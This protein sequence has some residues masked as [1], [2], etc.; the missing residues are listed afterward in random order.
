MFNL[1]RW[2]KCP[3]HFF[4][5]TAIRKE[6]DLCPHL[7]TSAHEDMYQG[8]DDEKLFANVALFIYYCPLNHKYLQWT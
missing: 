7:V 8:G 1:P 4:V 6:R 5:I 2:G 3:T